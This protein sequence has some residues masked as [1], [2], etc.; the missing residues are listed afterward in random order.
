MGWGRG[1]GSWPLTGSRW[2]PLK[3]KVTKERD[4]T[5]VSFTRCHSKAFPGLSQGSNFGFCTEPIVEITCR[6]GRVVS[7]VLLLL[8]QPESLVM[9]SWSSLLTHRE[10]PGALSS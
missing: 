7:S 8:G 1:G 9:V 3:L 2:G 5:H 6:T 10:E 4:S